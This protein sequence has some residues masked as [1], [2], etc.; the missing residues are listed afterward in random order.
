MLNIYIKEYINS[1]N[2]PESFVLQLVNSTIYIF[3]KHPKETLPLLS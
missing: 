3:L 1:T 2:K